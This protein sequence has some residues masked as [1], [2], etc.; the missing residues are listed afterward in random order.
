MVLILP[1]MLSA[2]FQAEKEECLMEICVF[3]KE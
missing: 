2:V 1:E 3:G